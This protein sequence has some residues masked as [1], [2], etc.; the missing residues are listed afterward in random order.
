M[1]TCDERFLDPRMCGFGIPG[2]SGSTPERFEAAQ[3][4]VETRSDRLQ[5]LTTVQA[6]DDP[7][8]YEPVG[9][10]S[11]WERRLRW[12]VDQ[13]PVILETIREARVRLR[14]AKYDANRVQESRGEA[15]APT[16]LNAVDDADDLWALIVPLMVECSEKVHGKLPPV[17]GASWTHHGQVA[18][19]PAQWTPRDARLAG[20]HVAEWLRMWAPHLEFVDVGEPMDHLFRAIRGAAA[21]WVGV[22]PR[23]YRARGCGLCITGR[24]L[25][26]YEDIGGVEHMTVECVACGQGYGSEPVET[27]AAGAA[28][29]RE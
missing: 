10:I 2:A 27:V 1:T 9:E 13:L 22:T 21:R 24:V 28:G 26:R 23:L 8:L 12:H 5:A 19:L 3:A 4:R 29:V 15:P 7:R 6:D 11:G 16:D 17:A 14:A 20:W 18:G 25:I